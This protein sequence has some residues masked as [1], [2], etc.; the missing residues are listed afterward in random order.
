MAVASLEGAVSNV[1]PVGCV[2]PDKLA[3]SL[4]AISDRDWGDVDETKLQSIWPAE[5][6]GV[7]CDAGACE[8]MGRRD[9]VINNEC[10][11]CELFRF[12][13][14][15]DDKGAVTSEHLKN[16]VIYYSS[17]NRKALWDDARVLASA[18]G[19]PDSDTATIRVNGPQNFNWTVS[20]S[21]QQMIALLEV[22]LY[23]GNGAWTAY[24]H[25]SRQSSGR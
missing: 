22:R 5:I 16:V 2:A 13:I 7:E 1:R 4:K 9:R 25:L 17:S 3:V 23:Y 10:Q 15:R 21:K 11:C 14:E 18:M 6:G 19:L 12:N 24:L 20:K 8:T